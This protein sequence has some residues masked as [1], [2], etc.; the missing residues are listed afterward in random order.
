M[1]AVEVEAQPI[2]N[3]PWYKE[4]NNQQWKALIG[5]F[6]GWALDA[7]DF[8]LY[9]FVIVTLIKEWGLT[10]ASTGLVAS[11]TVVAS[12]LG[13][14]VF[15]RVADK[16]G[17]TKALSMTVL[18]YSVATMLCG[19]SPNIWFLMFF[20]IFVGL[21]MGGEWSA[22]AALISETWPKE[23]RGKAMSIM[24]SGYAVG[25]LTAALVAGPLINAFGWRAV[26]FIG[27]LP[28]L[29]VFW[30]RK[31]VEE[32]KIWV[33]NEV[34]EEIQVKKDKE[35][36]TSWFDLF[37]G[38]L[39]KPTIIGTLFCIVGLGASYPIATWL[40]AYLGTPVSEGGAGFNVVNASIFMVP[41]YLGSICGYIVYGFLS[42]KIGRKKSFALFFAVAAIFIP[43]FIFTGAS[44][45]VI[46]FLL[47]FIVGAAY[48]GYYGGF[49]TVLA[50]MFPTRLRGSGQGFAYNV[51]RGVSAFAIT[52]AGAIAITT[53]L[54]TALVYSS[55]GLYIIAI[56]AVALLPETKGKELE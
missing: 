17:R 19:L 48:C 15:G 12:A 9:N 51:G 31:N 11:V 50:E 16:I 42:D 6:L 20:R 30:I 24:Q 43:T 45:M 56:F 55:V 34:K 52:G 53:G 35:E 41:F 32:P 21:G 25:G 2:T 13:G 37:R 23:H 5:A 28:A 49:G 29:L 14:I 8:L 36:K 22:G 4:I 3:G 54:G 44:N 27:V 39:L 18:I 1:Q 33:E 40:P 38:N 7:F 47:M 10:T 26:F 46:F